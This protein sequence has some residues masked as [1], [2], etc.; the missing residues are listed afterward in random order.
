MRS[1][2]CWPTRHRSTRPRPFWF[3]LPREEQ[4]AIHPYDDYILA[5]SL[6]DTTVPEDDLFAGVTAPAERS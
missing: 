4:A 3:G 5:R 6:V 1:T 2:P